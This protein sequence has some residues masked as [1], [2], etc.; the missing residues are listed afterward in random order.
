MI[1]GLVKTVLFLALLSFMYYVLDTLKKI[2][3]SV[4]EIKAKVLIEEKATESVDQE[5]TPTST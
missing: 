3:T 2:Q 4:Y 1:F 5:E